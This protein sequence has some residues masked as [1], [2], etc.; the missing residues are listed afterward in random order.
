MAG[1][2]HYRVTD[3][4][5]HGTPAQITHFRGVFE[6]MAAPLTV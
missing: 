2:Q 5:D 3:L 1:G 6:K 4:L